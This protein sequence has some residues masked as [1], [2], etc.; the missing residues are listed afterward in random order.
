VGLESLNE[1]WAS[2]KFRRKDKRLRGQG[3]RGSINLV[4]GLKRGLQPRRTVREVWLTRMKAEARF[5]LKQWTGGKRNGK[6]GALKGLGGEK[7]RPFGGREKK[8]CSRDSSGDSARAIDGVYTWERLSSSREAVGEK[9]KRDERSGERWNR[10]LSW[11]EGG[12]KETFRSLSKRGKAY[13]SGIHKTTQKNCND[14]NQHG[15]N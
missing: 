15:R 9:G 12:G 1:K 14:G 5:P 2:S 4:R 6:K 7:L 13:V 8:N 10:F 3:R 11:G